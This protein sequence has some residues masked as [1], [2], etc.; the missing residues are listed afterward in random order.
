MA[1][2][3]DPAN[4]LITATQS[5]ATTNYSYDDNGN[6]VQ[7]LPP[8]TAITTTYHNDIV[9][10]S[11]VLI[12]DDGATQ[13]ANLFGLDL[14]FTQDGNTTH[15]LLADGLGTARVEMVG[16]IIANAT[17]YEPY[18]SILMQVGAR[19][20]V[21]GFTGEQEDAATNLLYLRARYYAPHLKIFLSKDPYPGSIGKPATQNGYNYSNANPVNYT[22]PSG[23]C[24][25]V[26]DDACWSLVEQI[27]RHPKS[28]EA[29][30]HGG[31]MVPIE[32]LPIGRLRTILD[33]L[34][35]VYGQT[36]VTSNSP[37]NL[38]SWLYRE[39]DTNIDDPRLRKIRNLN[40]GATIASG[41]GVIATGAG[42]CT[43]NP[44]AMGVGAIAIGGG[45]HLFQDARQMFAEL[46]GDRKIWDFKH[47][48]EARLGEGITLCSRRECQDNI[49]YS[50]PGN[51]HFGYV[52]GE[53]GYSDMITQL[54]AGHAEIT[55]P[56]HDPNSPHYTGPYEG[57]IGF[58]SGAGGLGF[59]FGDDPND[60]QAV[61][62]GLHLYN[63]YRGGLTMLQFKRELARYMDNF[64]HH[65]P[66]NIEVASD[67]ATQWPYPLGYFTPK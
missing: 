41:A 2:A 20:T 47:T 62:F 23:L 37:R 18:G 63:R 51:I 27:Q 31:A 17:T 44:A 21:Y 33:D 19:G 46:V 40:V 49:E 54:G 61:Q 6:L 1:R 32:Q 3:F 64:S 13:T 16:A 4:R 24:A 28:N 60:W 7:I 22:D 53:A 43:V 26:G 58:M 11:Q 42:I 10:L 29:Y 30:L 56:A 59:N 57:K 50:V 38:T 67:V 34:D 12:A 5:A 66:D 15:T 25:E 45:I 52:A 8:G 55:D 9:G 35:K 48:I 65:S 14:I 36:T 39:M